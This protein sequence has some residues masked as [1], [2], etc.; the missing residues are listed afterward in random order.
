MA[1]IGSTPTMPP[2]GLPPPPALHQ[3]QQEER[4]QA[5]WGGQQYQ[6]QQE[7]AAWGGQQ[8]QAQ[9]EQEQ[10][11]AWDEQPQAQ[12]APQ[13]W[14]DQQYQA[15]QQQRQQDEQ[16]WA[17]YQAE[18]S[19]TGWPAPGASRRQLNRAGVRKRARSTILILRCMSSCRRRS[20][21]V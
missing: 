12:E 7:Q 14:S 1:S 9:Q 13:A 4:Q 15:A 21:R 2:S 10:E 17:Q 16:A 18:E 3:A 20:Q 19:A 8:Y 11:Q 6:A 5:A